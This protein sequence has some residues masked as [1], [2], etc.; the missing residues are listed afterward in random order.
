MGWDRI[1][2]LVFLLAPYLRKHGSFTV[3][4]LYDRTI[5]KQRVVAVLCLIIA[6]VTYVIGQTKGIGV[7]FLGS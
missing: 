2:S 6:S 5:L 4:H 7:A 3:P 1:C